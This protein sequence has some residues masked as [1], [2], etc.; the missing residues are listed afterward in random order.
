MST[1]LKSFEMVGKKQSISDVISIIDP[2]DTPFLSSI[3]SEKISQE[4]HQWMEDKLMDVKDNAKVEGFTAVNSNIAQPVMRSNGSQILS[5]TWEVS[6][7]ADATKAHGR[8][9]EIARAKLKVAKSV[10]RDL[11]HAL[12]GTGQTYTARA[13]AVAGRLAGVQAQ[14]A[15][16]NTTAAAGAALTKDMLDDA[17][18]KV[19]AVGGEPNTL[20]VGIK[21]A[22]NVSSF[23]SSFRNVNDENKTF[24]DRVDIYVGTAG[25]L[26]V[27]KTRIVRAGDAVMYNP[28]D[29]KLLVFR[30]WKEEALAKV[31]DSE[32]GMIVGEFSLKHVNQSAS[33]LIS[34]LED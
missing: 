22:F 1:N 33:G 3:K 30:D 13:G 28:N 8:D 10:K 25:E 2:T 34:G 23:A 6:G 31:G 14:I 29:W 15:A 24:T 5:D 32:R 12:V 9:R 4:F 16:G 19:W 11:E 27:R 21:N 7:S 17:Q 26:K 20:L 18:S